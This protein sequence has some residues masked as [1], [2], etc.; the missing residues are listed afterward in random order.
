MPKNIKA[1]YVSAFFSGLEESSKDKA[2]EDY[3][4]SWAPCSKEMLEQV[5][6]HFPHDDNEH[7]LVRLLQCQ[8]LVLSEKAF[9]LL[10]H[11]SRGAKDPEIGKLNVWESREENS[12]FNATPKSLSNNA[13]NCVRG[14]AYIALAKL[15]FENEECAFQNKE[16]LDYAIN[17]EHP[18]VKMSALELICPFLNYDEDYAH[19]KFLELCNKEIRVSCGF[20]AYYFFN[21]GFEGNYRNKYIQLV[22]CML[23]SQYEDVRK[24]AARQIYARWFFNALFEDELKIVINGDKVLRSG[25]ASVLEQFLKEDKYHDRIGKIEASY[26][27]LLNDEDKDILREVG[28]CI[29]YNNYWAKH[30]S[31]LLFNFFVK[32]KSAIHC[33]NYLFEKL[34]TIPK[35]PVGMSDSLLV[36][37]R[38]FVD[39]DKKDETFDARNMHI[40][41]SSLLSVLQ[42]IYDEATEDED[43]DSIRTCL[44]IWD[45]LLNSEIDTAM[46]SLKAVDSGL[47]T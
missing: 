9:Q 12:A 26:E 27:T 41:N 38:N 25:C 17:D 46:S 10:L 32:S 31:S 18:A 15:F 14:R 42:R 45:E 3:K 2:H 8:L 4:D 16:A 36:L 11:L 34:K 37:V 39:I 22:L 5:I 44:D 1:Q 43:D 7:A 33:I 40:D 6:F 20:Q 30:N 21:Q 29:R 13:I 23:K 47:L 35:M 28:G 19:I 24:E